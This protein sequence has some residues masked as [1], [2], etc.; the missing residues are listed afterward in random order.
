[1]S[2]SNGL[3]KGLVS[4][5]SLEVTADCSLADVVLLGKFSLHDGMFVYY[6]R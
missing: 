4:V 6:C 5:E 1:M 2:I 3:L